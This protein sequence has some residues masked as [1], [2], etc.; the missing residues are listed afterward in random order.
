MLKQLWRSWER[1]FIQPQTP[2]NERRVRSFLL[3][4]L[5]LLTLA[6]ILVGLFNILYD[7]NTI[8]KMRE[9]RSFRVR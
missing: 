8:A 7:T 1:F 9:K 3:L 2:V 6:C 5:S 4:F